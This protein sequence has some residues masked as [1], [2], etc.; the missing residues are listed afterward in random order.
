MKIT[1]VNCYPVWGG[2]RNYLF[3]VVDTDAGIYGL[4]EAGLTGRELAVAGA[5]DH[6]RPLLIGQDPAR[7][8][9][10]WQTLS[11]GGFF[12]H[13]R[14]LGSALAAV[15]IALWD[16]KGK[17]LGVPVYDL[18]GGRVRDSVACYCH[19][20]AAD[21]DS[22]VE[23][24]RER[25]DEGWKYVRWAIEAEEGI[26][27][28]TRAM[29]K[30]I[31]EF[32]LMRQALGPEVELCYD[33]HTRLSPTDA[34]TFCREIQQ[35]R[36]FFIEDPIRSESPQA[37][38]LLREKIF[39]PLAVGEQFGSK[40]DF[41]EL[42]DHD[43]I[44]YARVDLCIAAGLSE[45]KKIAGWCEA[46]YIDLVVHNPLGPVA[47]AACV[48]LNLAIP[49]F[50]VQ[51]QPHKPGAFLGDVVRTS[52]VWQDG[53]ILPPTAPGLGLE[54]DRVAAAAHPFRMTELPHY[55][56]ADGSLTNW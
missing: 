38:H 7:I 46:H 41:R 47:T 34:I 8:E 25:V 21:A 15:D 30:G 14:I 37:F 23:R 31:N 10:I 32:R 28:P 13:D 12:P 17:A 49:N 40:W 51:E 35:Y 16:I 18:L 1:A 53:A 24:A 56:R 43:L 29:L 39:V 3:V 11:R 42:I 50:A 44:D 36:P 5:V 33:V 48:H 19:L 26:F 52:L 4:G 54:F 20:G 55:F 9:Y 27:E 45:A 6:F 2:S 22:L